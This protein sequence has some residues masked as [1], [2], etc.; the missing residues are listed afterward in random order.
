MTPARQLIRRSGLAKAGL[1][2][3]IATDAFAVS[4]AVSYAGYLKSLPPGAVIDELE[5]VPSETAYGL[6]GLAQ[7]VAMIFSAV[8]FIRWFHLAHRNLAGLSEE[9]AAYSS[10]WAIGAFFVPILNLIRPYQLMR[11][12]WALTSREWDRDP[13]RVI[14]VARPADPVNLWWGLFLLT[15]LIG[16]AVSRLSWRAATAQDTLTATWVTV[17]ADVF[18]IGA[19]FAALAVIRAVTELQ[20]PLLDRGLGG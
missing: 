3:V 19:A 11:E 1:W 14:G 18:N 9:P 10:R 7:L 4:A 12:I 16:N 5:L 13:S 17:F 20:R 8:V 2:S 15:S 6:A